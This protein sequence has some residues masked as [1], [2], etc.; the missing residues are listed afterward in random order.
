MVD[1]DAVRL[2]ARNQTKR[3]LSPLKLGLTFAINHLEA[4]VVAMIHKLMGY[5]FPS[6]PALECVFAKVAA[7]IQARVEFWVVV[8]IWFTIHALGAV[9]AEIRLFL[10]PQAM[11]FIP[12]A[13]LGPAQRACGLDCASASAQ[14]P[15]HV[16]GGTDSTDE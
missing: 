5:Q 10:V 8:P 2:L 16:V 1:P 13:L 6:D 3:Q 4:E 9:M 11:V 15:M 7:G 14:R 12:G